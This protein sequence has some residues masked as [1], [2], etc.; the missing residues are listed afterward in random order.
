M[1]I[2]SM[3]RKNLSFAKLLKYFEKE[4]VR[5]RFIHNL[6]SKIANKK[7]IIKEFM[8]N[9]KYLN[10]SR[11]KVFLYH[12]ILSLENNNLS[13]K[14]QEKILQDLT[15]KYIQ[16]RAN[17]H[18]VYGVIHQDTNNLHMHLMISSNKV[19]ENKR[20]RLSKKEFK[21]IQAS[22]ENYKN[23]TYP[24]LEQTQIYQNKTKDRS[25]SKQKEQEVKHRRNKQTKKEFLKENLQNIFV[26]SLSKIALE[27]SLENN[28]FYFY[29][30]ASN[31]SIKYENRNYRL[32]ILGLEYEYKQAL[33]RIEKIEA[34]RE[35]RQ[36]FK[37]EKTKKKSQGFSKER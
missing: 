16:V 26:R 30:R 37:D 20:T 25:K 9:A 28:G 4:Q 17:E 22:L 10:N 11:G 33:T 34:R 36:S 2:K 19:A 8:A 6:Y 7:Q 5:T 1:I 21:D 27:N 13:L 31:F 15:H 18:L 23:Q 29:K 35:K 24:N 3:S 14:E 12:E 32:K